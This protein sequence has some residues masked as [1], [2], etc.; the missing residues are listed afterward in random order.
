MAKRRLLWQLYPS[1][2]FITI[3]SLLVAT[4]YTSWYLHRFYLHKTAAD[5]EARARMAKSI[6]AVEIDA[7]NAPAIDQL[8]KTLGQQSSTRITVVAPSGLVLGDTDENPAKMENH[9][10]RPEIQQ[11][12]HGQVGVSERYSHT[13]HHY[14]MYVAVPVDTPAGIIG[15]VRTSLPTS[16]IDLALR[17][18]GFHVALSGLVV[19]LLAALMSWVVSRR[20]SRPLEEIRSSARRFAQG[21]LSNS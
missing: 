18:V 16:S 19:A 3:I 10:G 1:Y 12:F 9:A 4:L 6:I 21:D 14:M 11:A 8:C 7:A 5:L 13:L 20:I 15:V 17:T 2:L